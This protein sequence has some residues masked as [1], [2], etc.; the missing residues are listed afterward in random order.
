LGR[1]IDR[2]SGRLT[3]I[4]KESGAPAIDLGR[5]TLPLGV[6]GVLPEEAARRLCIL[7]VRADATTLIVAMTRPDDPEP[8]DELALISGKKV[9]AYGADPGELAATIDAAYLARRTGHLVWRGGR[10]AAPPQPPLERAAAGTPPATREPFAQDAVYSGSAAPVRT[11]RARPIV[12]VVDDEPVIRRIMNDALAQRGYEVL[13]AG[14]GAEAFRIVKQRDPDAI[15][16]DAMLP[17]VHGFEICRRLK[18]SRRYRHI[19]IIMVTAM[20]KGWRMAQDLKEAYGVHAT[21]EKPFDIHHLVTVLEGAL[22]GRQVGERPS[23]ENLSAE[24]QRLYKDSA[25]AYRAG[26]LDGAATAL[27]AAVT[28]DPLSATLRHQLGLLHAQRGHDFAAMQE[29]EAAIDLEPARFQTLRNLAVLYQKHGFRR[30][31]CEIWERALSHAPD[32]A[33]GAEI[34]TVLIKLL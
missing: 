9:I 33:T 13:C 3:L 27:I 34:R 8:I 1:I 26:D 21:V 30:K 16:L 2:D 22:A 6:L 17:D 7:P 28:I 32:E 10:A 4:S 19:P 18:G 24:A 25:A 20:Y 14:G 23:T 15:L 29:L 31:S 11:S 12:L 5:L